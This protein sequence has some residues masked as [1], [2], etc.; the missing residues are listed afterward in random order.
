MFL[1]Q[2]VQGQVKERFQD[3]KDDVR[4]VVFTQQS[5]CQYCADNQ[6]LMEEIAELSD[7]IS[8]EVFDF[9]TDKEQVSKYAIDKV[10]ATAIVGKEDYGIRLYGI[11]AGYDFISLIESIRLVSTGE[12]ELASEE[13]D[14]LK[15]L[16]KETHLQVFVSSGCP[17]CPSAAT[18]AHQM[19]LA[20]SKV[21][22]DVIDA[23]Q[24]P[25]LADKY[26]VSAVPHTVINETAYQLGAVPAPA[27]IEKIKETLK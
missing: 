14:Y 4:L 21:K 1:V 3:L 2:E 13:S 16:A 20:S 22:A 15:N 12:T 24:F 18:L 6:K 5:G 26:N 10:P 27:I 7:K 17:H 23:A 25:H 11:P 19:A 9:Q 8:L